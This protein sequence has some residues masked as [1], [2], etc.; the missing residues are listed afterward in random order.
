MGSVRLGCLVSTGSV[1][2]TVVVELPSRSTPFLGAVVV[3]WPRFFGGRFWAAFAGCEN[4]KATARAITP[5]ASSR[6]GF[7][8]SVCLSGMAILR[9]QLNFCRAL[10]GCV[11]RVELSV[12]VCVEIDAEAFRRTRRRSYFGKN[13]RFP[14]GK[15][16]LAGQ[17][18]RLTHSYGRFVVSTSYAAK[19]ALR[20]VWFP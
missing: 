19:V 16:W 17:L 8:G 18:R 15:W 20:R 12:W 7:L 9:R 4:E 13:H 14:H 2:S 1:P 6:A 5:P 10:S 11:G 3:T